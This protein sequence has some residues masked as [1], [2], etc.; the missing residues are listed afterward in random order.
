MEP[1]N[2][3]I[4][5]YDQNK[6]Q[7]EKSSNS[8]EKFIILTNEELN[9]QNREHI[10][11]IESL[12]NENNSL[13]D[14]NEKLETSTRYMRGILHNFTEKVKHQ[15][16]II[17][18]YKSYHMI[19][20]DYTK[21]LNSLVKNINNFVKKFIFIY[22]LIL[23]SLCFTGGITITSIIINNILIVISIVITLSH[24]QVNYDLILNI[25]TKTKCINELQK[26]DKKL[27]ETEEKKVAEIDKSNNFIEDY[28]DVV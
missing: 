4:S 22:N 10:I 6:E 27:I 21:N 17:N 2:I 28:I 5:V 18:Y 9:N 25:E 11:E 15:D 14:Q 8:S 3:S 23:L 7:I 20:K 24:T 13:E 12:K 19:L 26:N 1:G 16:K